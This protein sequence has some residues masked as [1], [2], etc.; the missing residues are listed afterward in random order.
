MDFSFIGTALPFTIFL[1]PEVMIVFWY[2][3]NPNCF[4]SSSVNSLTG[5][6]ES[7]NTKRSPSVE[8]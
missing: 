2:S 6:E 7:L 8:R 3:S 1:Y 4:C 5:R